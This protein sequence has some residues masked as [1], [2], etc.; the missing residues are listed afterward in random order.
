[1]N[2]E[3][4]DY[5]F[6]KKTI[7]IKFEEAVYPLRQTMK[8]ANQDRFN[9]LQEEDKNKCLNLFVRGWKHEI[10]MYISI[11]MDKTINQFVIFYHSETQNKKILE[12]MKLTLL[13]FVQILIK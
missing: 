9:S 2:N 12:I 11:F 1:M 8:K 13:I 6:K 5:F 10:D 4:V 3:Q 7:N